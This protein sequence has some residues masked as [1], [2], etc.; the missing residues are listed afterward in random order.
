M[1]MNQNHTCLSLILV[2]LGLKWKRV[3]LHAISVKA[4]DAILFKH[5]I[6]GL[7]TCRERSRHGQSKMNRDD[8]SIL[9]KAPAVGQTT[10][11]RRLQNRF[12]RPPR[13]PPPRLP[14]RFFPTT[15]QS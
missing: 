12:G 14:L 5:G 1:N 4:L 6:Q 10:N 7:R 8:V 9:A 2:S 15:F 3:S 13:R 11:H